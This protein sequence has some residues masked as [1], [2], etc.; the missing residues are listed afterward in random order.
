MSSSGY[1]GHNVL[2]ADRMDHYV[3]NL[4]ASMI[5]TNKKE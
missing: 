4:P 2:A 1:S 3:S 5:L